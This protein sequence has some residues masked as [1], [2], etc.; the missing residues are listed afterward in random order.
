MESGEMLRAVAVLNDLS[1][2][3][4]RQDRRF[5]DLK[6]ELN[7]M[8]ASRDQSR[9][10]LAQAKMRDTSHYDA[11]MAVSDQLRAP[12]TDC[13]VEALPPN[14]GTNETVR[15]VQALQRKAALYDEAVAVGVAATERALRGARR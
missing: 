1:L 12:G 8:T 14:C 2:A 9:R 10:E 7:I 3:I 11:W 4:Q 15:R 6:N 5:A 13:Q